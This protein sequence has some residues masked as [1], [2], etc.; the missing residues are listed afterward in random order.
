MSEGEHPSD[1]LL[2]DAPKLQLGGKK[3]KSDG[4]TTLM[5]RNVPNNYTRAMFLDMMNQQGFQGQYDFI[6]LP[7]DFKSGAN[8]GYAFVNLVTPAVVH[9]FWSIFDGFSNWALPT[10]KVCE[11]KWSGPYQGLKAHIDRYRNSSLMH[12]AMPDIYKPM[13]FLEGVR[14]VF[15][16]PT[17]KL[18]VPGG[19]CAPDG[20]VIVGSSVWDD[21]STK[22]GSK[23]K[24][25]K[26]QGKGSKK[27]SGKGKGA[28]PRAGQ[29]R[30]GDVD[31]WM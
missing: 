28:S 25:K 26:S 31:F 19:A 7:I 2:P 1:A 29:T 22:S 4:R 16:P 10:L 5:L 6:Y 21:G 18:R 30:Q 17:R 11:V 15:P 12:E 3:S 8:L 13:V 23:A 27:G 14:A 24:A 20:D 9:D